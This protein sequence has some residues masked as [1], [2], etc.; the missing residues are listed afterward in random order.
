MAITTTQVSSDLIL[1]LDNGVST[2][3]K[4]LTKSNRY[5]DVKIAAANGDLYAIAQGISGLQEKPMLSVQRQDI[6]EIKDI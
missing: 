1:V 6:L 4:A 5:S 3:G 2:T